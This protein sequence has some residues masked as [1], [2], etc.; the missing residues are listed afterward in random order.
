MK[1]WVVIV[2][3]ANYIDDRVNNLDYTDDDAYKMYAFYKSQEGGSLPDKQITLLIDEDATRRSVLTAVTEAYLN[4]GKE[5]AVI[6]YFSGHGSEE[7]FVTH[8][9]DGKR[10][11]DGKYRGLLLHEELHEVFNKSPAKYKYIIADACHSGSSAGKSISDKNSAPYYQTFENAKGG[12]VMLLSSMGNEVSVE[13]SG[14]RQG[15][16]SHYLLR[17]IKGEADNNKDNMVAV[18]ELF[19]FVESGVKYYTR[20]K[21]NPVMVGDYNDVLPVSILFRRNDD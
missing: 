5:D 8:E 20:N 2:G 13:T 15:V 21:Q 6:F 17:G 18:T 1:I 14:V 4:A 7:A 3:V 19:D 11:D 9:Y 12:F 10:D 16:F